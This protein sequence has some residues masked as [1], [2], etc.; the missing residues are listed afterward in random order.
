MTTNAEPLPVTE[1]TENSAHATTSAASVVE[2][3]LN[4]RVRFANA[5]RR[6]RRPLAAGF[7]TGLLVLGA[8]WAG[9]AGLFGGGSFDLNG[10]MTLLQ[11]SSYG[12]SYSSYGSSSYS[13]SAYYLSGDGS[14]QGNG[15]YSDIGP[16]TAVN[17]YD[18][19]GAIVAVGELGA[20]R[21]SY[22]AGCAFSFSVPDVPTGERF[23]QVEVSHRGKMNL[24]EDEAQA[25]SAAFSLGGN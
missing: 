10:S 24:T 6:D 7:V 13:S 9:T 2:S 15:G 20:G 14:C 25:G 1:Q 17:V 21:G 18:S 12:S 19:S 4:R 5:V 16:G 3:P 23:Y 11:S 8:I 22:S